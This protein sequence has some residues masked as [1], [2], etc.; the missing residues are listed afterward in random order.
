MSTRARILRPLFVLV[1]PCAVLGAF[2]LWMQRAKLN[3]YK[4]VTW[5]IGVAALPLL[6]GSYRAMFGKK[7][8][9]AGDPKHTLPAYG[10]ALVLLCY[11]RWQAAD[12]DRYDTLSG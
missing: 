10:I 1:F 8:V 7:G 9:R 12:V 11:R 4:H 3:E 5:F 6:W 2:A